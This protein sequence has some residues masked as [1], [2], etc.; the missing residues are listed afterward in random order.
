MWPDIASSGKS[1][2]SHHMG[3][4]LLFP[5]CSGTVVYKIFFFLFFSLDFIFQT[6]CG[7]Q[8]VANQYSTCNVG[9]K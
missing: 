7:M 8:N 9:E 4:A 2:K 6:I 1:I 3:V 5:L